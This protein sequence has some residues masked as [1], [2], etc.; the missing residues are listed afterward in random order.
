MNPKLGWI[1]SKRPRILATVFRGDIIGK[2][3]GPFLHSLGCASLINCQATGSLHLF[4]MLKV[5]KKAQ[6]ETTKYVT[7]IVT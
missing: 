2:R 1:W 7:K 3:N 5:L 6:M 4:V